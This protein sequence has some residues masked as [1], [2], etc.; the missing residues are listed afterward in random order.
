MTRYGT[1]SRGD[2]PRCFAI[3]DPLTLR[4]SHAP[5]ELTANPK[6]F[7]EKF[8]AIFNWA[9]PPSA[10]RAF[11]VDGF[12]RRVFELH[13]CRASSLSGVYPFA[14]PDLNTIPPAGAHKPKQALVNPLSMARLR[15]GIVSFGCDRHQCRQPKRDFHS[16]ATL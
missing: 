11:P 9:R 2:R 10:G 7:L 12:R 8:P 6:I 16:V 1:H 15:S 4:W 13:M 3:W 5:I 14:I